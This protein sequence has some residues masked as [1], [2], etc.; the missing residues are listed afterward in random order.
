[1]KIPCIL[2][3]LAQISLLSFSQQTEKRIALVIGNSNYKNSGLLSNPGNDA[4]LM[5]ATLE[6]LDFRV[7]KKVNAD[8]QQMTQ[9]IAEFWSELANYD[10][11][12]FFYAGHGIQ[13]KGINYILPV[14][15]KLSNIDMVSFEA[16][17]VNDVVNKFE[18]YPNHTNIVILDACRNNPFRAWSR[19]GEI[20]FKAM[21]PGSGTIIAFAT[22]EGSA[23]S[24]G[25]GKNGLFTEKFV[26]QIRKPVPIETVFKNTRIEVQKAS[27]NSQ[28]PQEWTKLT[29]EFYFNNKSLPKGNNVVRSK[30]DAKL[31]SGKIN[32][33]YGK[34]NLSSEIEGEVVLDNRTMDYI[35]KSYTEKTYDSI[36]IGQH[37]IEIRGKEF[38][39]HQITVLEGESSVVI[40]KGSNSEVNVN[41]LLDPRDGKI[42]NTVK[43]GNQTWMAENLDFSGGIC[44]NNDNSNCDLYGKLYTLNDAKMVCPTGW[45]LPSEEEWDKMIIYLGG[46]KVAGGKLKE[47]GTEHWKSPN[48]SATNESGFNALP[49]GRNGTNAWDGSPQ[50]K[51]IGISSE[52]WSYSKWRSYSLGYDKQSIGRITRSDWI[53]LSVRCVKNQ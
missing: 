25:V 28:N 13:V 4:E 30:D 16:I 29:G 46:D 2:L 51:D 27:N 48:A 47:K 33:K 19:G 17:S 18:L 5:A 24:D 45:H 35:S 53:G 49:G 44:Y 9:S 7:I 15:A 37:N 10:V 12:L 36:L 38:Q 3:I 52:W 20:G 14:D 39:K 23:A 43:I 40:F 50:C 21:N 22:S 26:Q 1:M 11:A 6:E 41:Q 34:I 42:Y 32:E 8:R 31:I